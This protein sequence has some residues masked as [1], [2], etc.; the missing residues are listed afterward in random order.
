MEKKQLEFSQAAIDALYAA[1]ETK[2]TAEKALVW[3][4]VV[5]GIDTGV[6]SL[7]DGGPVANG[8]T[9]AGDIVRSDDKT[10]LQDRVR[11]VYSQAR[12]QWNLSN[13]PVRQ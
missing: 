8:F 3:V 13:R 11:I 1:V 4:R 10:A 12:E 7:S 2:F 9:R 6:L 5:Q